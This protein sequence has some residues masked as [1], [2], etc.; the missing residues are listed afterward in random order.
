MEIDQQGNPLPMPPPNPLP[1]LRTG[2][3]CNP[4][5]D[6]DGFYFIRVNRQGEYDPDG[7]YRPA[8]PDPNNPG[9]YRLAPPDALQQ[10]AGNRR[11][12]NK[13]K[14]NKCKTNKRKTNKRKR[15]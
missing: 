2:H 14:T 11:K 3:P 8:I 12:T 15:R 1:L 13:R 9:C 10:N 6:Y 4:K 5:I 7:R